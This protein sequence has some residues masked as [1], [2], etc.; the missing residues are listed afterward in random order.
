MTV[1]AGSG[2]KS[3]AVSADGTLLYVIPEVGDEV[4]VYSV[5]VIAGV[6]AT[7]PD[8]VARDVAAR[9]VA[10][11]EA[12]LGDPLVYARVDLLGFDGG[13]YAL[14]E[15]ELIEPTLFFRHGPE[16]AERLAAAVARIVG[17]GGAAGSGE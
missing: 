1:P 14:N 9:A 7:G 12:I 3:L 13:G 6:S 2:G 8:A 15:L 11:A 17:T 10:A 4:L 5:E 16:A